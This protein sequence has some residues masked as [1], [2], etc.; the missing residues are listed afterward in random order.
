MPL[1][2]STIRRYTPPTCTLEVAA[3]SS[4]LSRWVGKS[5]LKDLRFELR[6]DDPRQSEDK[7]VTIRGDVQ[8]LEVLCD[9]VNR[10]VQNLLDPSQAQLPLVQKTSAAA[11][12]STHNEPNIAS[13]AFDGNQAATLEAQEINFSE[14]T[15]SAHSPESKPKLRNLKN[16]SQPTE[17]SL[18]PQGL[19]YHELFLA[20]LASEES[21]EVVKL[22]V[23]QLFDLATALD[24]YA[25]DI[26][27]LPNLNA[28]KSKTKRATPPWGPIAAGAVLAV[29]VTA[30]GVQLMNQSGKNQVATKSQGTSTSS[31]TLTPLLSQVPPPP[32]APIPISP[33]PTPSVPPTL[34]S[35]PILSP[36]GPVT[37]P[38][39]TAAKDEPILKQPQ[40]LS[41][42]PAGLTIPVLPQRTTPAFAP[43]KIQS[44][45]SPSG[46]VNRGTS[47]S[48]SLSPSPR[49]AGQST[50]S[51]TLSTTA[52][53]QPLPALPANL[54]T[55]KATPSA[56]PT[57]L[58]DKIITDATPSAGSPSTELKP[59]ESALA[60]NAANTAENTA[61]TTGSAANSRLSDSIPQVA[62]VRS[63]FQQRWK[64]PS[65]LTQTLEYSLSL[66]ADGSIQRILPLGQAAGKYIDST[67]IPLPEEPF[68]SAVEGNRTPTIRVVF[69]PDG[70]VDTFL[71]QVK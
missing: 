45:P 36:P 55:L 70:K 50:P 1:S 5:V 37:I 61:N 24:E 52:K 23:I 42:N 59:S 20:R 65:G 48:P 7:R 44:F 2:N 17:I 68:V 51:S 34:A 4:P 19:L 69:T 60:G 41:V 21:G 15:S 3:K 40:T 67:G 18:Q 11:N 31:P 9:S 47:P 29:G 22:T 53:L 58:A 43:A 32:T 57:K 64:P 30:G 33:L 56:S 10:Y 8:A 27:A 14:D 49:T 54:P 39:P 35:S 66:N 6:F 62:E 16:H 13:P 63:Y 12:D 38:T 71:E 25:A 28:P 26:V 46:I